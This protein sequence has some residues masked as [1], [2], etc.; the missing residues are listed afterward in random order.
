MSSV[1]RGLPISEIQGRDDCGISL[2]P[3]D[4]RSAPVKGRNT[5]RSKNADNRAISV[6]SDCNDGDH[7]LPVD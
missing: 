2:L 6:F 7:W 3:A 1:G 5:S 4:G